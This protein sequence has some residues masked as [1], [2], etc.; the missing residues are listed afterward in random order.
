[1]KNGQRANYPR[2]VTQRILRTLVDAMCA[3]K[4]NAN[5][6]RNGCLTLWNFDIPKDI[7]SIK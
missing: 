6:M 3:H 1:V 5:M 2:A 7:V 4:G